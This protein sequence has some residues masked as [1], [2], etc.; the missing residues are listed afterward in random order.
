MG[1]PALRPDLPYRRIAVVLSGGGALG[2]YEAGVL[3]VLETVRLAPWLLA[4][5]SIGAVNAVVW[6]AHGRRTAPLEAAWRRMRASTIGLRW[7][8]MFARALGA[9]VA[10]VAVV[11]LLL[12]ATGSRELSGAYWLWRR[13]SGRIDLASTLLDA[14]AWAVLGAAGVAMALLSRRAEGWLSRLSPAA[15]PARM[16]RR[17]GLAVLALAALHAVVWVFAWPWPHRFS[18][19]AVLALTVLWL[20]NR[21]GRT[22]EVL[23]GVLGGL[24]P[25]TRGRG[26]WGSAARRRVIESLVRAGDPRRLVDGDTA[27]VIGALATDT[28]RVAH[29]TSWR[30]PSPEFVRRVEA[31]LGEVLPLRDPEDALRAAVASSAI[32]GVFEPV[33]IAGREFVDAVGL[34]NQ[35]LHVAIAAEADAV[36]V[37]LM[38][39]AGS[40]PPSPPAGNLFQLA[41]RLLEVANWRDLQA[42]LRSLPEG[43]SRDGDPAR[44]CVVEPERPLPGGVLE[45]APENAARLVA[46]GEADAWR[47][48]ERAGWTVRSAGGAA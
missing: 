25:E 22:G 47:A 9:L 30:E 21:P 3:K 44:V 42:E 31:E 23:R 11:E 4:G 20:A 29:F 38:Y 7:G 2:A 40:P 48:L 15:D 36:L 6:L 26:L 17:F 32:P 41:G 33:R 10:A 27:L 43:W 19:F 28:G 39:P 8:T 34:S 14:T 16:H 46:L 18:A 5:V 37:V 12:L 24:M 45:F 1:A 35:P 13:S